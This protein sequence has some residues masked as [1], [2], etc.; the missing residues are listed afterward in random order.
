MVI[1][2]GG[3]AGLTTAQALRAHLGADT[4]ITVVERAPSHTLGLS[5]LWVLR[6]WRSPKQVEVA[7]SGAAIEGL[8]MLKAE[9][10]GI[11][12]AART[13]HT[14]GGDLHYDALVIALGAE[15]NPERLAGLPEALQTGAA[16]QYYTLEGAESVHERLRSLKSGKLV[17]LVSSM[18]FKCPAAPYEGALLAADLLTETGAR[19]QV[20]IEV[21]TPEP[22]PMPVA[23]PAVGAALVEMLSAKGIGF[24]PGRS[25]E[26]VDG[27]G[28]QL[29]FADGGVEEFD[30][31]VAI[32][33]HQAP[34]A[35]AEAGF[36]P[37]GWVPV[38]PAS[39][40]APVPG[41]WALGDASSVTLA[42]GKPLPKAAVFAKGEAVTVAAGV[43]RY[44]GADVEVPAFDGHGA[45]Y[46]EIGGGAAAK[47]AGNFYHPDG[48]QV[49]LAEPSEAFHREKEAEEH[50]WQTHWAAR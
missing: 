9:V 47:G 21:Y 40:A 35:V 13:V 27:P 48:P 33:P 36:S 24:H 46:V 39:L 3:V 42:N 43:A 49:T 12:T 6:G 44:L 19:S 38:D 26:R 17:F 10:Q 8:T 31:L 7:P 29:V 22:A 23:G 20:S 30:Y 14:C 32:P 18:P 37:A 2:G 15:V 50:D 25:I 5:L 41:V 28:R 45:C 11:D 16:G 4:S 34:A 1:L